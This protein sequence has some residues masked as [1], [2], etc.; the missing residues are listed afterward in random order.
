MLLDRVQGDECPSDFSMH[1]AP[2]WVQAH[3]LQIRAMNKVVGA[4]K[5]Q[6]LG[7]V[8]EVRSDDAEG[9]ALGRCIRIRAMIDIHKPL[10]QWTKACIGGT[11][12][13]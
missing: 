1:M 4:E 13:V 12:S 5:G 3:G 9:R 2:F 8:I 10:V 6:V 7:Q 11:P